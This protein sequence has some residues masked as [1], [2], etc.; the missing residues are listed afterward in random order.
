MS[1]RC[2]LTTKEVVVVECLVVQSVV[3][4]SVVYI[5]VGLQSA[6]V[7]TPLAIECNASVTNLC[8]LGSNHNH[9][10]RTTSTIQCVRSSILLNGNRLDISRVDVVDIALVRHTVHNPQRLSTRVDRTRSTNS[11]RSLCTWTTRRRRHLHT[12]NLTNQGIR[13]VR[14]LSLG[15]VVR[16]HNLSR[17]CKRILLSLTES[18]DDDVVDRLRCLLEDYVYCS[19]AINGN[20]GIFVTDEREYESAINWRAQRILTLHI[21]RS[22]QS[23]TLYH[24]GST[25]NRRFVRSGNCT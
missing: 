3:L 20:L 9:T 17:T 8:T 13:Y 22:T 15:Q 21:G 12:G 11:D 10:I 14:R 7:E 16:R 5:V 24:Y 19:L 18:H 6:S 23:G 4:A 25:D 1:L 2:A